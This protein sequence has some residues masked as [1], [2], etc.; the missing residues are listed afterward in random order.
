MHC[1]ASPS[2]GLAAIHAY[3]SASSLLAGLSCCLGR[4]PGLGHC[5]TVTFAT[6][7]PISV[8]STQ[9]T[10][11]WTVS[12]GKITNGQGTT[13]ITVDITGAGGQSI[14]ATVEVGGIPDGCGNK[15]SCSIIV[16]RGLPVARKFDEYGDLPW[17]EERRPRA[18][19]PRRS[20]HRRT[21]HRSRKRRTLKQ[22]I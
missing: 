12:A 6:N 20:T 17:T 9:R 18:L 8:P 1:Y 2:L 15:A 19:H 22:T 10:F 14:T 5:P 11:N 3:R 21:M 7:I 13:L 16:C 4:L